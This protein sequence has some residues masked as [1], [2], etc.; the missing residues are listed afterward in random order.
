MTDKTPAD[1][2]PATFRPAANGRAAAGGGPS[3]G[4]LAALIQEAGAL[5][6]ALSDARARAGRLVVAL[7][8]HRR[9]ERLV[10]ST[11][12]SLKALKLQDVAG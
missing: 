11:L 4:G 3:A 1:K 12:A 6:E 2:P 8:K 5:H 7:R 10:Q 9:R